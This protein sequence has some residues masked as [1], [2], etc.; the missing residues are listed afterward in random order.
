MNVFVNDYDN[1]VEQI[2]LLRL[3]LLKQIIE[4]YGF[5]LGETDNT[6]NYQNYLINDAPIVSGFNS[7]LDGLGNVDPGETG[8]SDQM[9]QQICI[10]E[11]GHQ[12]GYTMGARD[13]FGYDLGDAQGHKT[14][15]YGLLYHPDG[16]FMDMRQSSYTQQE[17]ENLYKH[18]VKKFVTNVKNWVQKNGLSLNQNKIDAITCACY[19]FG[20][21]FL[22][23][24][25][26]KMII[27]NPNDPNIKEV[28]THLSDAQGHKYPGLLKRRALEANWYFASN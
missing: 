23:K 6:I 18:S 28:W 16:G 4:Y 20:M 3:D 5:Y 26:A 9:F 12:F 7:G 24:N 10:F 27:N 8:V 11:T 15:G 1:M 2:P 22:N 25:I 14:F 13:L 17:L 19:N 21:G